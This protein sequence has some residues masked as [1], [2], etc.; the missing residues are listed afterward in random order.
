MSDD[1]LQ[2]HLTEYACIRSELQ[3]ALKTM[4]TV[5]FGTV[6][7]NAFIVT[8]IVTQAGT[9]GQ[10]GPLLMIASWLPA[11]ITVIAW[12]I[13]TDRVGAVRRIGKYCRIVE[14]KYSHSELGWESYSQRIRKENKV[15][16]KHIFPLAYVL[17]ALMSL[18][19]GT[20]MT[21]RFL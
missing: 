21:L 12:L 1:N 5:A 17:L 10:L 13:N 8:W 6:T 7:A 20:Y 3:T 19:F 18:G 14:D 2:F 16:A 11:I 4:Y 9:S 15:K